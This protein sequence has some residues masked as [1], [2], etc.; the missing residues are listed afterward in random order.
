MGPS[1]TPASSLE[2]RACGPRIEFDIFETQPEECEALVEHV[3]INGKETEFNTFEN[4]EFFLTAKEVRDQMI[5]N[6]KN[7]TGVYLISKVK[8]LHEMYSF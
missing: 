3:N 6:K 1:N 5:E 4:G 7:G 8:L 2:P